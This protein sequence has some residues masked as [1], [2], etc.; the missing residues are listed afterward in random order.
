MNKIVSNVAV[1]GVVGMIGRRKE[2]LH[3]GVSVLAKMFVNE[4]H[5]Y[6]EV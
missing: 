6:P 2:D 4:K 5:F 1:M 3:N